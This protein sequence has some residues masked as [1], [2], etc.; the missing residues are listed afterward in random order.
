MLVKAFLSGWWGVGAVCHSLEPPWSAG[1]G[2]AALAQAGRCGR[3]H[4]P[5]VGFIRDL[6]PDL[7][8]AFRATLEE[9]QR[10]AI[11]ANLAFHGSPRKSMYWWMMPMRISAQLMIEN[12]ES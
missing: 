7:I 9:V 10:A 4:T 1:D 5:Q 3:P 2:R 8:S 12:C 6:P 11:V